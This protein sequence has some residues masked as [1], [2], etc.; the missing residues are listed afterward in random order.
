MCFDP[1]NKKRKVGENRFT[2]SKEER[3]RLMIEHA[4][5]GMAFAGLV[6]CRVTPIR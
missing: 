6:V 5:S 3:S 4:R 1:M 2:L